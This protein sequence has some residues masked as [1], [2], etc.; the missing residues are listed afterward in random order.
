MRPIQE[1]RQEQKQE[2]VQ[3]LEQ[4][5]IQNL[6]SKYF[7]FERNTSDFPY[8]N[9]I[10]INISWSRWLLII[11][12]CLLGI[13]YRYLGNISFVGPIVNDY[14]NAI[15]LPFACLVGLVLATDQYWTALFRRPESKD[16]PIILGFL[17]ATV[18]ALA[19]LTMAV[20]HWF[21]T[22]SLSATLSPHLY[23]QDIFRIFGEELLAILPLLALLQLLTKTLNL[24]RKVALLLALILSALLFGLYHLPAYQWNWAQ[25]F[26]VFGLGRIIG[27][28]PYLVTHNLLISFVVQ[29]L[30]HLAL[31]LLP[32]LIR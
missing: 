16:I 30:S 8:Y 2:L 23:I 24:P 28:L 20:S 1:P 29:Y 32:K 11:G 31:L 3:E 7:W 17:G 22:A 13:L 25:C 18:G 5:Q 12:C 21:P 27:S 6:P 10:P 9:G 15:M 19:L 14:A 4:E 26:I